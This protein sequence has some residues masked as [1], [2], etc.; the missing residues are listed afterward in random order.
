MRG[1]AFALALTAAM[2]PGVAAAEDREPEVL[3]RVGKWGVNEKSDSCELFAQFGEKG[4]AVIARFTRFEP[5][6]QFSFTLLGRRM[7]SSNVY[8]EGKI[9]FGL[10]DKPIE[11]RAMNGKLGDWN[12]GFLGNLRLDGW[13]GKKPDEEG[14]TITAQQEAAVSGVTVALPG[15]RPF[16][17]AFGSLAK[18]FAQ[19]RACTSSM[20]SYWGYDS[21]VQARLRRRVTP[22]ISPVNWV[23]PEE[24]PDIAI[25]R[26][27]GGFVTAR[28]DVD[29]TGAITACHVVERTDEDEFAK[30]VCRAILK[31][32]RVQPALD[33]QGQAVRS[34][35]VFRWRFNIG[36]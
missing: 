29:A 12:A 36:G 6:E 4:D 31:R 30:T 28:L 35:K 22:V 27:E 14:P 34:Y 10:K 25:R 11:F 20:V 9:D 33:A 18:P 23:T 24:Y 2:I 26:G 1:G 32:A 15:R 21:E 8:T 3:T 19:L 13:W 5:G 7:W 17:L 16:R